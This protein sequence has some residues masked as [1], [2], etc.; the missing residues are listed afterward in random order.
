VTMRE[1]GRPTS[2]T[3][4]ALDRKADARAL[5]IASSRASTT[6]TLLQLGAH[7]SRE[8]DVRS[9]YAPAPYSAVETPG[10]SICNE[11]FVT[12]PHGR[13][14]TSSAFRKS[15]RRT[16]H[17]RHVC[18][19]RL[20]CGE[21]FHSHRPIAPLRRRGNEKMVRWPI[22]GALVMALTALVACAPDKESAPSPSSSSARSITVNA[23][24]GTPATP[25]ND[26]TDPKAPV[27]SP[28]ESNFIDTR[29]GG[30]WGDRCFAEI[31][32]GK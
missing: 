27:L 31:K 24:A 16:T 20:A 28:D 23:S 11:F 13:Y 4:L 10:E 9:R 26:G 2:A 3:R 25:G 30:G 22:G 7:V 18:M 32:Q 29:N 15:R 12:T 19:R 1:K 17:R 21:V 14:V 8:S 6:P 5:T